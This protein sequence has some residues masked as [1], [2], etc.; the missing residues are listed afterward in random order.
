MKYN[1]SM[2]LIIHLFFWVFYFVVVFFLEPY[3]GNATMS[4]IDKIDVKLLLIVV[5]LT[6]INDQLFLPYFFKNKKYITYSLLIVTLLFLITTIYCYYIIDCSCSYGACLS[7]NLWKFVLPIIFLS[8]IWILMSLFEKQKELEKIN[9]ER[10]E[11]ELKFL[12]SQINPHVLF[13][14]LNTIYSQAVKG[15]DNVPEMILMLSEN[16]KYILYQSETNIV[17]LEKDIDFIDNYLEF[18]KMRTQG[19]NNIIYTKNIDSLNHSIAP[20]L[21]IGL[22]ENAFKHSSYKENLLSDIEIIINVQNGKL[23]F[24]CKNEV[25]NSQNKT[26]TEGLQ[27][28]L[29]NL[30][31]RLDLMYK[32]NYSL[33]KIENENNF[34]ADLKITLT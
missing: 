15:A 19:I 1:L 22:I 11:I 5:G 10:L 20:L 13:N 2:K 7:Q 27:I 16:L 3:Y 24:I 30:K 31:Q 33:E 8:L 23:H 26:N 25:D 34:I 21:L 14:N 6:Y 29:K 9:K 18:Q 28:G 12:K 17:P 32:G 4:W